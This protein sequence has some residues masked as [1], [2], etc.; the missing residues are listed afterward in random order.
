MSY[1]DQLKGVNPT[2]KT[3]KKEV[4]TI[5]LTG[6]TKLRVYEPKEFIYNGNKRIRLNTKVL[7]GEHTDKYYTIFF[8][9][10]TKNG[11]TQTFKILVNALIPEEIATTVTTAEK[12]GITDT[13]KLDDLVITTFL[14]NTDKVG[15][16]T[17]TAIFSAPKE[18]TRKDGT[19]GVGQ[20]LNEITEV[21]F[22]TPK[23]KKEQEW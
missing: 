1:L 21:S 17:V 16:A 3:E 12:E 6:P 15:R 18:F 14:A 5:V 22:Y 19:T 2:T 10:K 9:P 11:L 20:F 8:S 13:N 23:A 7:S 4:S